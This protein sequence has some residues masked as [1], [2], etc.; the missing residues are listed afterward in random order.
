MAA[1]LFCIALGLYLIILQV[2]ILDTHLHS[3]VTVPW[4]IYIKLGFGVFLFLIGSV[5][6]MVWFL[7]RE[8]D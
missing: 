7:K 8:G 3:K 2:D 4:H 1:A 5:V 6:D